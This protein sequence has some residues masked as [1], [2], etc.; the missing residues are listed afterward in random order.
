MI[1]LSK[2]VKKKV[3]D[4]N[5]DITG[6]FIEPEPSKGSEEI[7]SELLINEDIDEEISEAEKN[8]R[9]LEVQ[10]N[11]NNVWGYSAKG[12]EA[13]KAAHAMLSTKHGL[14]AR[15]PIVCKGETCPYE[16][17][18]TLLKYE[19]HTTGEMCPME[20]A[21]IELRLNEYTKDFELE[22]GSFTDNNLV[23]EI[24]NL[25]IMLERCKALIAKEGVPV[26]DVIAGMAEN[27][28][29]FTRPEVSIYFNAYDRTQK[30]RNELYNLMLA[31]RKDKKGSATVANSIEDYVKEVIDMTENG[32]FV[33]NER[34]DNFK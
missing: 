26:I 1:T 15:I 11:K 14:Y 34:P 21:Q 6:V 31:T 32:E 8:R 16:E 30:R 12:L 19:L 27:G 23:S 9:L 25:D 10:L 29:T 3:D 22:K 28:E 7:D 33:I 18:C 2:L 13:N 17:S 4:S 24:I 5:K 20:T